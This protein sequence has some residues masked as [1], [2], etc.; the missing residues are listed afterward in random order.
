MRV[1]YHNHT[2]FSD[3]NHS[4]EEMIQAAQAA[5]LKE[6]GVSDHFVVSP[7]NGY[8]ESTWTMQRD[9]LPKYVEKIGQLKKKYN[10]DHFKVR[11]GIEVDFF[12]DNAD[13]VALLL[14]DYPFDYWIGAIHY[15]KKFPIDNSAENWT[16]LSQNGRDA[17]WRG[18][19]QKSILMARSGLYDFVAH[20]D[21]PKKFGFYSSVN[22]SDLIEELLLEL[23]KRHTP[24]EVNTAGMDKPCQEFYPS[25][26]ILTRA[27][28]LG[29]PILIN[30]DAHAV[31]QITRH[32]SEA[33]ALLKK[34]H[35]KKVCSIC[36]H[37]MQFTEA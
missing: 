8:G 32:Y 13:E 11:L 34:L 35:G 20:L 12:E 1:S 17:V 24:I 14:R 18:Y 7:G 2:N 33:E 27:I 5:G 30:T 3:G 29:L 4:A 26:D 15:W 9:F 6:F 25:V 22:N 19:W 36:N 10:T 37:K 31:P 16:A 21:L 28:E 23:A